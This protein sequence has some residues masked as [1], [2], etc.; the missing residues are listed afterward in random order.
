MGLYVCSRF[1]CTVNMLHVTNFTLHP[2]KVLLGRFCS[3]WAQLGLFPQTILNLFDLS[4][5]SLRTTAI[6]Y[7][8]FEIYNLNM[9]PSSLFMSSVCRDPMI[10]SNLLHL[11]F[12]QWKRRELFVCCIRG[13]GPNT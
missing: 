12:F 3:S 11:V 7:M 5:G 9:C 13:Y 10:M 8:S 6:K 4:A 2:L 1:L